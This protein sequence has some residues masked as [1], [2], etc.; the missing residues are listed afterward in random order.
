MN[1]RFC[2]RILSLTILSL[3]LSLGTAFAQNPA[4]SQKPNFPWMDR[5]L[6]PDERA[7]MVLGRMTLDEKMD[8]VHGEGM[9]GWGP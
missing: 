9:P 3:L 7:S 8:L 4:D 2:K 1:N 6:T 5:T